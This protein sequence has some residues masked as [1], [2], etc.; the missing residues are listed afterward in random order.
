MNRADWIGIPGFKSWICFAVWRAAW[1]RAL[2]RCTH[3]HTHTH[4][5]RDK[6]PQRL[7]SNHWLN[8]LPKHITVPSK[9]FIHFPRFLLELP[10]NVPPAA[11]FPLINWLFPRHTSFPQQYFR[12]TN[13]C[14]FQACRCEFTQNLRHTKHCWLPQACCFYPLIGVTRFC[15][16]SYFVGASHVTYSI[17]ALK[18]VL[19]MLPLTP[20]QQACQV[21]TAATPT[22]PPYL[23]PMIKFSPSSILPYIPLHSWL[24][25]IFVSYKYIPNIVR[26][27]F[28]INVPEMELQPGLAN[29]IAYKQKMNFN[30]S[31]CIFQFNNW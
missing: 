16:V 14:H 11:E 15:G 10:L 12:S 29:Y 28:N 1:G 26:C 5:P 6:I 20:L 21:F 9:N 25:I 8:L 22:N 3:T 7:F 30:V 13:A 31:P 18:Y 17:M 23:P 4:T 19:L 2:S 24:V 27:T